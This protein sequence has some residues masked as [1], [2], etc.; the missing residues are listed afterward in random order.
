MEKLVTRVNF[1]P[2]KPHGVALAR[3]ARMHKRSIRVL[4]V[5]RPEHQEDC[6]EVGLKWSR[7]IGQVV[8][9]GSPFEKDGPDDGETATVWRGLQSESCS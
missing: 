5:V 3:S 8:K 7:K 9:L 1:G 4:F 2:G 6:E